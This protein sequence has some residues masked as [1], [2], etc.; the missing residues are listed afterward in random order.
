MFKAVGGFFARI[1]TSPDNI[2]KTADMVRDG[3]DKLILTKEETKDYEQKAVENYLEFVKV[4]TDGGHL[5]RR[6]I[7]LIV[8]FVWALYTLSI[9]GLITV[10]IWVEGLAEAALALS[11]VLVKVVLP[12]FG[13]VMLFY[14]GH[15]II[16][17]DG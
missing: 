15:R 13:G 17:G 1:F 2:G 7:G 16:K 11:D 6:L 9:G 12:S 5:A 4:S 14:F 10:G 8:T 3:L